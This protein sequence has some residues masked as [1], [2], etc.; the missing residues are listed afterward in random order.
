MFLLQLLIWCQINHTHAQI[1]TFQWLLNTPHLLTMQPQPRIRIK[2]VIKHMVH[3]LPPTTTPKRLLCNIT[4]CKPNT[5]CQNMLQTLPIP[6]IPTMLL[7]GMIHI[8]M[9]L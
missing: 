3:L 8:D 1:L 7:I 4:M 5:L 9:M 2:Q 6:L